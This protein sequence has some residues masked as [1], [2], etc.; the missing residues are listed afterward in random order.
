MEKAFTPKQ[1]KYRAANGEEK[2]PV[3]E[4]VG[5]RERETTHNYI[6]HTSEVKASR[7]PRVIS[8]TLHSLKSTSTS[9][10]M[11]MA[12][13]RTSNKRPERMNFNFSFCSFLCLNSTDAGNV[14]FR[15][16]SYL[17]CNLHEFVYVY[18][19]S[20]L[21]LKLMNIFWV[22]SS[23]CGYV[24]AH[25]YD[26]LRSGCY[27]FFKLVPFL[28]LW[29][30]PYSLFYYLSLA[31][32]NLVLSLYLF[33]IEIWI[34]FNVDFFRCVNTLDQFVYLIYVFVEKYFFLCLHSITELIGFAFALPPEPI[35]YL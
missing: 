6:R 1:N 25:L 11:T 33:A 19:I 14:D 35:R 31:V 20:L 16:L 17:L 8:S 10:T 32:G 29:F 3:R 24:W 7:R 26:R 5:E 28:L 22:I 18:L 27:C 2:A 9:S 21:V 4:R 13:T 30:S 34:N 12:R 23:A 15:F